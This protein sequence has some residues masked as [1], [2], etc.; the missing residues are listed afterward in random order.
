M[1]VPRGLLVLPVLALL[2]A[3]ALMFALPREPAGVGDLPKPSDSSA[4]DPSGQPALPA[5]QINWMGH[6]LGND[7][8][9]D[10]VREVKTE[11]EF[12]NPGTQIN[13]KF[14]QELMGQRSKRLTGVFIADMIKS[15]KIDWNVVWMDAK[16]YREVADALKDPDWG[17]THLVDFST[18]PGFIETQKPFIIEDPF[19][20]DRTGGILIGPHIEGSYLSLF[21]NRDVAAKMGLSIKNMDMTFDDLV[22]YVK[23][24]DEYNRSHG[25]T[26]AA[27]H[28]S[29][30]R[31]NLGYIFESL[32]RSEFDDFNEIN[33]EMF[34]PR[35]REAL[36]KTLRAF[37]QLGHS[38]PLQPSY[39]TSVWYD[40]IGAVLNDEALFFANGT[41]MYSL[42]RGIDPVKLKKMVPAA[43]PVFQPVN[44][45][46]GSFI[47][48]FAVMKNAPNRDE[49][50]RLVMQWSSSKVAEKWVRYTKNPTGV[51]G[52]VTVAESGADPFEEFGAAVKTRYG[53]R[54]RNS[55]DWGYMLGKENRDLQGQI[56]EILRKLLAGEIK[57]DAA[58]EKL[59]LHLRSNPR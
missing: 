30:D 10:L 11:F 27:F 51:R 52:N 59:L 50:I 1:G 46:L 26:I 5:R 22:K 32:F 41:W 14:P 55:D 15:G 53:D 3:G 58:G 8:R 24:V 13:L 56:E 37:E 36:L 18:V 9:E 31:S 35:K 16:I 12:V 42:W 48:A 4:A 29:S 54:I 25:T 39:R 49:A 20:R 45:Y 57:A 43:L 23:A 2:A 34:T 33:A 40:T 6:W 19:Y 28:E 44:H 47:T 38:H 17:K 21:Y 7:K